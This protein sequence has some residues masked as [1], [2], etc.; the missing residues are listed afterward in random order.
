MMKKEISVVLVDDHVNFRNELAT[1]IDSFAE[2]VVPWQADNGKQLIKQLAQHTLPDIVLLDIN[3]PEMDG[4]ETAAW[5]KSHYP[6]VK[7]LAISTWDNEKTINRMLSL[8]A[9]GFVL[10][11][12]E[13]TEMKAAL[14]EVAEK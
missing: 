8:G 5:L 12:V 7:V 14:L 10:K 1:V 11:D 3:M 13:P 9:S 4:F 2:F 6:E